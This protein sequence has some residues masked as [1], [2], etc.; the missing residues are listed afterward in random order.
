[1]NVFTSRLAHVGLL[2]VLL[3]CHTAT[4]QETR[5]TTKVG[6][7]VAQFLKIGAGARSIAMGGSAVASSDNIYSIYWNPGSL[8]RMSAP[9]EVTFSHANWLADMTYD[10]AALAMTLDGVGTV[11]ISVTSF[12]VPDD[13]VRTELSP[14]GDGRRWNAGSFAM[15]VTF[16]R[17]LTDKFSI[18]F[19]VKYIREAIWNMSS[20]GFAFD[21]G[22]IYTTDFNGLKI[23]A[24]ISNF[25]TKMRLDGHDISFD[26]NPGGSL[27][28]G[29]QN[30]AALYRTDDFD[31][32]LNFKV[33]LSMD[34]WKSEMFRA[35]VAVDAAHPNDNTEYVNTGLEVG[36]NEMFFGRVGYK[37]LF[38][39]ETEE[40]LTWGFGLNLMVGDLTAVKLDYAVADFGRLNNVQYLTLGIT[41]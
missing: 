38:M 36:F 17:A 25:G 24:S 5:N 11:G 7:T 28:Q 35:T 18:G 30:V 37:S 32:P 1:M 29:A 4:A 19:N 12:G 21:I 3:V 9:G 26:N 27:G 39:E 40:G 13:I 34:A 41:Y 31:I 6:T 15:G 2:L 20:S 8:T 14:E 16:A 10:F 23:G 22:T 33:G